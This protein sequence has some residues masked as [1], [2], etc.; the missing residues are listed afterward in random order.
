MA[1]PRVWCGHAIFIFYLQVPNMIRDLMPKVKIIALLRNPVQRAC[2]QYY[3]EIRKGCE[4]LSFEVAIAQE[5]ARMAGEY[6]KVMSDKF[7]DS[8]DWHDHSYMERGKYYDQLN[9]W[10]QV[11]PRKP[12]LILKSE[13]LFQDPE[14]IYYRVLQFLGLLRYDKIEFQN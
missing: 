12:F 14:S 11:F 1:C 5:P 4:T 7:Y 8:S 6:E 10:F 3:H 13:D 2:S 9:R